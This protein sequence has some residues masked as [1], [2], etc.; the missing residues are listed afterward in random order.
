M[1]M[2]NTPNGTTTQSN[3][4][5]QRA[6]TGSE[7]GRKA[8][9]VA[10]EA[11]KESAK[12]L[13]KA[14]ERLRRE[15]REGGGDDNAV[16]LTDDVASSLEK[17]ALYLKETSVPEMEQEL[18]ERVQAQPFQALLVAFGIGLLVGLIV[19]GR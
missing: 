9:Q 4:A 10:E 7:V 6:G 19:R 18:K 5:D 11:R 3:A 8:T 15:V 12:A 13:Q 14:A 17:T 16:Q 2:T 1:I